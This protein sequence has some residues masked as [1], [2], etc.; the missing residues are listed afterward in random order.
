MVLNAVDAADRGA[1]IM[2]RTECKNLES[3]GEHWR[4]TLRVDA[5]SEMTVDA[6]VVINAAGPWVDHVAGQAGARSNAPQV[7]LVKGSHIIV[8]KMFDDERCFI[9]QAGDGRVIFAI[10][11][12]NGRFTL[13]GTTDLPFEDD[14]DAVEASQRGDQISLRGFER[15]FRAADRTRRCRL[16]LFRRAALVRRSSSKTLRR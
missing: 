2:T 16:D 11:Y 15:I 3:K 10:P 9:F 13:I 5:S 1:T 8:P 14:L 12:E 7:R 6:K 4:A